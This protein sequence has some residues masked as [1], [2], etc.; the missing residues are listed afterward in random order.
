MP[1]N[2]FDSS[3]IITD[4]DSIT[5]RKPITG[6]SS[7][8]FVSM[9]IIPIMMP[10]LIDPVS[11]MKKRAGFILNQRKAI[12]APTIIAMKVAS[13]N[14]PCAKAIAPSATRVVATVPPARPSSPSISLTENAVETMTI[15]NTGIYQRP[16]SKF[17]TKGI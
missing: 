2:F 11:P 4:R 9:A 1:R 13:S 12:R 17:P 5:N 10:R 3:W 15:M 6:R 7:A 16:I 14:F 8:V